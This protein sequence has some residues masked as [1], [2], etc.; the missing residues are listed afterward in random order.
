MTPEAVMKK[1]LMI[2]FSLALGAAGLA[3]GQ[4]AVQDGG[5]LMGRGR[6]GAPYA[7]NDKNKDGICDVTGKAVG[8][9]QGRSARLMRGRGRAFAGGAGPGFGRGMGRGMGFSV[10]QQSNVAPAAK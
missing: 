8:Q 5:K 4:Q 6:G 7:W 1:T 3:V 10:N 9:R 2:A